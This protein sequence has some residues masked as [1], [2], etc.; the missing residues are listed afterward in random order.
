MWSALKTSMGKI[1][2]ARAVAL[3]TRPED[4][5]HFFNRLLDGGAGFIKQYGV[6]ENADPFN[7][8]NWHRANPSLRYFPDLLQTYREEAA[9]ARK[10]ENELQSFKGLRLNMGVSDV[11][12]AWLLEAS[13]WKRIEDTEA[14]PE[15]E[16]LLG[17]DLGGSRALSAASGFFENGCLESFGCF[18]ENPSLLERGMSDGIGDLY[19]RSFKEGHL[20]QA[21]RV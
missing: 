21:G 17:L 18:P 16:Y 5:T 1:P 10:D 7:E 8:R 6:S 9:E 11:I 13:S 12:E 4:E 15:G 20:I 3:G 2:G 14:H 19:E